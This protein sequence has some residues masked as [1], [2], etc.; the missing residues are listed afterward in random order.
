MVIN[1]QKF[2][3]YSKSHYKDLMSY[4]TEIQEHFGYLVKRDDLFNLGG[5][6]SGNSWYWSV[7]QV[8]CGQSGGYYSGGF[9]LMENGLAESFT[10][11]EED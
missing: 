2:P 4:E 5:I 3:K 11:Y 6:I 8:E 10:F 7:L 1:P 9:T